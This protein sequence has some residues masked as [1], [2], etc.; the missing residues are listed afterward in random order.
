MTT[1][2]I[3]NKLVAACRAGNW[4]IGAEL[5]ADDVVSIEA[6]EGQWSRLEGKAAVLKKSEQ[7]AAANKVESAEVF[8][9]YINGD[10]FAVRFLMTTTNLASGERQNM[11]EVAVYVVKNGKIAEE[12]FFYGQ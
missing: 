10:R 11:D 4:D 1:V 2:E 7:W 8:G 5:W 12:S 3:A 6:M 9:P